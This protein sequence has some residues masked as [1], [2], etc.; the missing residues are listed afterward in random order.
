MLHQLSTMSVAG[1]RFTRTAGQTST[2]L[3]TRSGSYIYNGDPAYFH[4]WEFKTLMRLKLY[5]DAIKAKAQK[6]KGRRNSR[7]SPTSQ[8]EPTDAD[9]EAEHLEKEL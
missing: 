7:R 5:E 2:P 8:D 9:V 6:K 1:L 4:D 3:E